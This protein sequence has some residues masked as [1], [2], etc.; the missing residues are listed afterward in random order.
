MGGIKIYS[1]KWPLRKQMMNSID[2]EL[3]HNEIFAENT[4]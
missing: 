4:E 2:K 1:L 3:I